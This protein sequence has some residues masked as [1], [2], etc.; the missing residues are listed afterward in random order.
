MN[1]SKLE[2]NSSLTVPVLD[3]EDS[4]ILIINV[5]GNHLWRAVGYCPDTPL[6]E[7][8]KDFMEFWKD[9]LKFCFPNSRSY[10][11]EFEGMLRDP[12]YFLFRMN[13]MWLD[14]EE[15]LMVERHWWDPLVS[16]LVFVFEDFE[17][18]YDSI[19]YADFWHLF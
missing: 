9:F 14:F 12:S 7:F 8:W 17:M 18:L 2:T 6:V 3:P 13:G 19:A 1:P 10:Y 16:D 11:R 15:Y 5:L 4:F